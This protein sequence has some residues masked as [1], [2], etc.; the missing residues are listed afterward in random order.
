MHTPSTGAWLEKYDALGTLSIVSSSR[1]YPL[2]LCY[3]C[4]T[5]I[6]GKSSSFGAIVRQSCYRRMRSQN[7]R[8]LYR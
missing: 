1:S 3:R 5:T 6:I 2:Q 8:S 4:P 7:L